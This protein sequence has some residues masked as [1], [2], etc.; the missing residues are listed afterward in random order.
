MEL[1]NYD[2]NQKNVNSFAVNNDRLYSKKIAAVGDSYVEGNGLPDSQ[3]WLSLIAT[4]NKMSKTNLGD[5]G[6]SL[7]EMVQAEAWKNIPNDTDYIVIW[8]GHNDSNYKLTTLGTFGDTTSATFYGCLDILCKGLMNRYPRARIL[9]ITPSKRSVVG[10]NVNAY[11]Y[12]DAM[13]EVCAKYDLVCWDSFREMEIL[14]NNMEGVDERSV[15]EQQV[16]GQYKV[17][18]NALGQEYVSYKIEEQ[19]RML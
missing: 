17:H 18:L 11:Q 7:Q 19:L 12:V 3:V 2:S 9:F 5:N 15:F 4:R 6:R 8:D 16:N 14:I 1:F 13:K 10:N